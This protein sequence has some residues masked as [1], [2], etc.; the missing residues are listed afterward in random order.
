MTANT[1]NIVIDVHENVLSLD[2][3][4][5]KVCPVCIATKDGGATP[6]NVPS[7]NGTNGTPI[8]GAVKLINQF[9]KNGVTRRNTT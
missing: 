6:K 1:A 5:C 9:G 7:A 4:V 3:I 8:T 2:D